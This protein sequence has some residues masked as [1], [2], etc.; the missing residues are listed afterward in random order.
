[1]RAFIIGNGP[2]LNQTPLDKLKDEVTF[3]VNRIHLIYPR[4]SWRPTYWVLADRSK[5]PFYVDDILIHVKE[6][7]DCWVRQDFYDDMVA[8]KGK[9]FD[10]V[11][12]YPNC[13]H[14]DADR[15]PPTEWHPPEFCIFG[16]SVPV[17]IQ[18]AISRGYDEL[19]VLGC[20]LGYKGNAVNH[21]VADY[22]PVDNRKV[23]AA[24][25][26]NRTLELAHELAYK[27]CKKLGVKIANAGIGG[28]LRA[29]PRVRLEDVLG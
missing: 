17:A 15:N 13:A 11:H 21:F 25:L 14:I 8:E 18:I 5:A 20:D 9:Q 24:M 10:A 26:A 29:Y 23:Q 6:G 16:G 4:T 7:E 12:L 28:E 27:E 1:M 19:Y 22:M 3:A 2:S